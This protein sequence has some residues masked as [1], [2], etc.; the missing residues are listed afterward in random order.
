MFAGFSPLG[1]PEGSNQFHH[2]TSHDL[3]LG[4]RW[5]FAPMAPPEPL[6]PLVR[7]G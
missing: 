5:L 1:A 2:I 3:T 7:K 4:V 6:Y